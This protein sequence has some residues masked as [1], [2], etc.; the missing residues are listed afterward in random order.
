MK[1]ILEEKKGR[2]LVGVQRPDTDPF[3]ETVEGDLEAALERVPAVYADATLQWAKSPKNPA[4]VAPKV[5]DKAKAS[6]PISSTHSSSGSPAKAA[7]V[8]DKKRAGK[9]RKSTALP[10][11]PA[12]P[13]EASLPLQDAPPV[14]VSEPVVPVE[15]VKVEPIAAL[16]ETKPPEPETVAPVSETVSSSEESNHSEPENTKPP[17]DGGKSKRKYVK[18]D[19][20][21]YFIYHGS[22]PVGPLK[23]VNTALDALGC[24]MELGKVP[25]HNRYEKLSAKLKALIVQR[26][27]GAVPTTLSEAVIEAAAK[28]GV[29]VK[30]VDLVEP[31]EGNPEPERIT[32]I[33]E[34][35]P[36]ANTVIK[37]SR[38]VPSPTNECEPCTWHATFKEATLPMQLGDVSCP[39]CKKWYRRP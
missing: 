22:A 18:Q 3:F 20:Y 17:S 5:D 31:E 7:K 11:T 10:E 30:V 4:Y 9:A 39:E 15:E 23:D 29:P 13:T 36:E 24:E 38:A 14:D 6:G 27:K 33:V 37:V 26:V 28:E 2:V 34:V 16:E 32:T 25:K 19:G 12:T 35:I 21:E 1:V 8:D